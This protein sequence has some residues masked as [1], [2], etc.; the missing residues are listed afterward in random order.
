M[1]VSNEKVGLCG[2]GERKCHVR[3]KEYNLKMFMREKSVD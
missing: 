1:M 2:Q 3:T